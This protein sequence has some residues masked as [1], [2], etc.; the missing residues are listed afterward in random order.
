MASLLQKPTHPNLTA[1]THLLR[2]QSHFL[3]PA[4]SRSAKAYQ[5][6]CL[7][8]LVGK[9]LEEKK[10]MDKQTEDP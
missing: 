7:D 9:S 3:G 5:K 2:N 1:N 4:N 10:Q 8:I 6:C